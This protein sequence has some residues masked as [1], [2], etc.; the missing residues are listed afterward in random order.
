MLGAWGEDASLDEKSRSEIQRGWLWWERVKK[1]R[2]EKRS[3]GI[4]ASLSHFHGLLSFYYLLERE[5]A[6]LYGGYGSKTGKS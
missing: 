2:E 3:K 5:G 4:M 1:R 6:L